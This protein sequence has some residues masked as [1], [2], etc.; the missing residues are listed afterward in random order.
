MTDLPGVQRSLQQT[1]L[2]YR[3]MSLV[4]LANQADEPVVM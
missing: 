4:N 2:A 1:P 3:G